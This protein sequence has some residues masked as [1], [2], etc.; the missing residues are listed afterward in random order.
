M[1]SGDSRP[2]AIMAVVLSLADDELV[3]AMQ[4]VKA[5]QQAPD[6][7][8]WTALGAMAQDGLG[9]ALAYYR[10]LAEFGSDTPD[11]LAWLRPI[12]ERRNTVLWELPATG[13]GPDQVV[14]QY[15]YDV[16][17]SV[18]L[19]G[20]ATSAFLP[21][22]ERA[23][24]LQREV[25]YRLLQDERLLN[26]WA[27]DHEGIKTLKTSIAHWLSW[28]GDVTRP[29]APPEIL[30]ETGIWPGVLAT[31]GQWQRQLL[32]FLS[33]YGITEVSAT[34]PANGREGQHT[35]YLEPM[36]EEWS[37]GYR[38]IWPRR[39][40]DDRERRGYFRRVTA[41]TGSGNPHA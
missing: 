15:I 1:S 23:A 26:E 37:N 3:R 27:T 7:T 11:Q 8:G 41:S 25:G 35:H 6:L 29:P 13:Y 22:A 38:E 4:A 28:A 16:W 9:H 10:I 17:D 39:G 12:R 33:P 18:R 14:R 24:S 2:I 40:A 34:C 20:L 31:E 32:R 19:A 30:E 36:L 21:L 5:L